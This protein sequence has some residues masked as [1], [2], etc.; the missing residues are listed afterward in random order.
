MLLYILCWLLL[1]VAAIQIK[2]RL[3]KFYTKLFITEVV[4]MGLICGLRDMLG[5]YDCYIYGEIFDATAND[6]RRGYPILKTCAFTIVYQEYA[7]SLINWL[8]A[9]VTYNRYIFFLIIS[10]IVFS[11]FYYHIQKLCKYPF[12][13]FF[14]LICLL[15]FFSFT[16]L[17]QIL[18]VCTAWFAIPFAIDRKP[19]LFFSIMALAFLFHN[20]A[21]LFVVIYFVINIKLTKLQITYIFIICFIT[22]LSPL[23]SFIMSTLGTEINAVKADSETRYNGGARFEYFIESVFFIYLIFSQYEKLLRD[24]I[25]NVMLNIAILFCAFLLMFIRF[26]DGGRMSWYFMIGVISVVPQVCVANSKDNKAKIASYV[27]LSLLYLRIVFGWGILLS[28]YKTFL[29]NGV[30]ENDK[31]YQKFE[32]DQYYAKDKM[33]RDPWILW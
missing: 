33:Y 26:S 9:H 20:S 10:I 14:V 3:Q 25:N 4:V 11:S 2:P 13:S 17:R 5:G 12:I 8:I 29:T 15:Y 24:K 22:G 16:Y 31:I 21:I 18:A 28:P 27:V 1:L 6:I 30:R 32:Y 7:Y 23:G 19:V